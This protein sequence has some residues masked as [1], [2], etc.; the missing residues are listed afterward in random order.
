MSVLS[1]EVLLP[2]DLCKIRAIE[3]GL[4]GACGSWVARP[5][6]NDIRTSESESPL[7]GS[8]FIFLRGGVVD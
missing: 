8:S 4:M 1:S 6:R 5:E 7:L 2:L 3:L